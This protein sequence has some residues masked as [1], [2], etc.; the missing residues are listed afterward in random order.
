MI[1]LYFR[2]DCS[3]QNERRGML[4]IT[5]FEKRL[6]FRRL[7]NTVYNTAPNKTVE[8]VPISPGIS[9]RTVFIQ[10]SEEGPSTLLIA[11]L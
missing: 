6:M 9:R 11:S 3:A 10:H 2:L 4:A 8:T 7:F 5:D 1:Y